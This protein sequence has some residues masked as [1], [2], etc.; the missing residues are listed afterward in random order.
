MHDPSS[1]KTHDAASPET[2]DLNLGM[3]RAPAGVWERTGW[4]GA[5]E[6]AL[7]RWLIGLGGG[8]LALEGLRRRGASGSFFAAL[9]GSF[10]CW[11]MTGEGDLSR[12]QRWFERVV[13]HS[14]WH[15]PDPVEHASADSFPASDPPAWT[16]IVGTGVSPRGDP[17][18]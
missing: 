1:R 17:A 6:P 9:G 3:H 11:A 18:H 13:E 16:P 10:A 4:N 15:R 7:T 5:R 8:A 2:N 12:A 14:P